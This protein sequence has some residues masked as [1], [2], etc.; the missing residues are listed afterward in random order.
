VACWMPAKRSITWADV[1]VGEIR[2]LALKK[3]SNFTEEDAVNKKMA[4][5]I[6]S[7]CSCHSWK[8]HQLIRDKQKG[9]NLP[10]IKEEHQQALAKRWQEVTVTDI[11]ELAR[12]Q[13]P[14]STFSEWLFFQVDKKQQKDYRGSWEI[15]KSK[16]GD[17]A[18]E[19]AEQ[20]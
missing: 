18:E 11:A 9:F 6:A 5:L 15:L 4:V 7:L 8:T 12:L 13:I 1:Q 20:R 14:D 10:E 16:L 19:F 3:E 17:Y 2:K